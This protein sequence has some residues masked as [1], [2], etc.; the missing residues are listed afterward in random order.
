MG[1][2]A[3]WSPVVG[4]WLLLRLWFEKAI[5]HLNQGANAW[6]TQIRAGRCSIF[7]M[8][9]ELNRLQKVEAEKAFSCSKNGEK[10]EEVKRAAELLKSDESMVVTAKTK[11]EKKRDIRVDAPGHHEKMSSEVKNGILMLRDATDCLLYMNEEQIKESTSEKKRTAD[12]AAKT[13]VEMA[14]IVEIPTPS[15]AKQ[16]AT[17]PVKNSKDLKKK[18]KD[19]VKRRT[20]ARVSSEKFL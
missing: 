1:A 8:M 17:S 6:M 19:E 11:P 15:V 16:G 7:Q 4:H 12:L 5:P 13:S 3:G 9:G 18:R 10:A 14:A 20:Q 2:G